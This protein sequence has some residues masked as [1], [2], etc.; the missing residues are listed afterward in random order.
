VKKTLRATDLTN[1]KLQEVW[2]G[3]KWNNFRG[4]LRLYYTTVTYLPDLKN[5]SDGCCN[6]SGGVALIVWFTTNGMCAKNKNICMWREQAKME[7]SRRVIFVVACC[8]GAKLCAHAARDFRLQHGTRF[9]WFHCKRIPSNGEAVGHPWLPFLAWRNRIFCCYCNLFS[10]EYPLPQ[11]SIPLLSAGTTLSH[12]SLL[13]RKVLC[14][15]GG[16]NEVCNYLICWVG[17]VHWRLRWRGLGV[18]LFGLTFLISPISIITPWCTLSRIS[19]HHCVRP[20]KSVS[21]RAPHLLTPTLRGAVS[22]NSF[23]SLKND[24][25]QSCQLP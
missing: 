2:K 21:N 18:T 13:I 20:C 16:I 9:S 8:H 4:S 10:S 25:C 3:G 6:L 17:A 12:A 1:W 24:K 23:K 22:F 5:R 7:W 14:Q 11:H 15:R 19:T